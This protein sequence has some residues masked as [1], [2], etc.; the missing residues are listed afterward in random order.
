MKPRPGRPRDTIRATALAS[1]A[2]HYA[3]KPCRKGHV[4]LRY[5]ST[6]AC[7]ACYRGEAAADKSQR[8]AFADIFK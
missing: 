7:V 8:D 4:G 3:G 2:I 1:G 5:V 6:G